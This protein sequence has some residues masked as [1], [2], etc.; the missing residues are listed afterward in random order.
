MSRDNY[1]RLGIILPVTGIIALAHWIF[2]STNRLPGEADLIIG[3]VLVAAG[4]PLLVRGI[5]KGSDKGGNPT[6]PSAR[7]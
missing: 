1:L 5:R 7:V 2:S 3:I 6:P 4:L